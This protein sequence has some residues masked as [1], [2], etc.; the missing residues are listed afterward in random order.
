MGRET[1][2][3]GAESRR[4]WSSSGGRC[5]LRAHMGGWGEKTR[6]RRLLGLWRGKLQPAEM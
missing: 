6:G 1:R 4:I 5:P 2:V 3:S